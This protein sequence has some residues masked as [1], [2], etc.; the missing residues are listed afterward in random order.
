MIN[1]VVT[2]ASS[3]YSVVA[4]SSTDQFVLEAALSLRIAT[5]IA[6]L[7]SS[8]DVCCIHIYIYM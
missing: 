3:I 7:V 2:F 8:S 6:V 4:S 5:H 1:D